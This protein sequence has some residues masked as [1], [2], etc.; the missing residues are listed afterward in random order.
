[1]ANAPTGKQT[2]AGIL[3]DVSARTPAAGSVFT[4][5]EGVDF[6]CDDKGRLQVQSAPDM[7]AGDMVLKMRDGGFRTI[8]ESGDLVLADAKNL[9]KHGVSKEDIKAHEKFAE[10]AKSNPSLV[11]KQGIHDTSVSETMKQKPSLARA[12]TGLAAT[13]ASA[14]AAVDMAGSATGLAKGAADKFRG[15]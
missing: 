10:N 13:I 5:A 11:A 1:M 3:Y 14:S 2:K 4:S 8:N 9:K 12:V 15:R 7:Q 6:S